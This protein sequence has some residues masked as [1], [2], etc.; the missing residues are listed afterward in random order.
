MATA[1]PIHTARPTGTPRAPD[2]SAAH[3]GWVATSAV[4]LATLV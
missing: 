1:M 2:S 4:A 3:T